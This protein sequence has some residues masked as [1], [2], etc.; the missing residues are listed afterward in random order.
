[1][2]K[3]IMLSAVLATFLTAGS[4][5]AQYTDSVAQSTGSGATNNNPSST[6]GDGGIPSNYLSELE[7]FLSDPSGAIDQ[8]TINLIATLIDVQNSELGSLV[9]PEGQSWSSLDYVQNILEG[10]T[11]NPSNANE[12]FKYALS[13]L[14]IGTVYDILQGVRTEDG[15]T[16]L[17]LDLTNVEN[18]FNNSIVKAK[19]MTP[20]EQLGLFTYALTSVQQKS[21]LANFLLT[22]KDSVKAFNKS[23][24][25]DLLKANTTP[26]KAQLQ[27]LTNFVGDILQNNESDSPNYTDTLKTLENIIK[28]ANDSKTSL[29][30][31]NV[32]I[33]ALKNET[34]N[35]LVT[36][37]NKIPSAPSNS[38]TA[39]PPKD[40][41]EG[42][43][44]NTFN[45]TRIPDLAN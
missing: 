7:Q 22:N 34:V 17:S 35:S 27:Q 15:L 37:N 31:T 19:G 18:A 3:N 29:N 30:F 14:S 26:T 39:I 10:S 40:S 32:P 11:V 44:P 24:I 9:Q 2:N 6:Q 41:S 42:T 38:S 12:A 1:M 28:S 20:K 45:S 4:L 23:I 5:T 36:K 43:I 13:A 25:P 16:P 33:A 21:A 8:N